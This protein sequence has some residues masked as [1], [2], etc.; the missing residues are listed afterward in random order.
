[1][2]KVNRRG[3]WL[4]AGALLAALIVLLAFSAWQVSRARCFVLVGSVTCRVETVK[5]LVALSFDDGPTVQ[6]VEA[7]L[8]ALDRAKVKATFFLIGADAEKRP[9]LV[10]RL[11]AAGH[12]IANHSYSHERMVGHSS[13]F[14]EE[15]IARTDA[16]LRKSGA[17]APRLFRPPYGKKLL[18]L[19]RAVER[20]GYRM[21]T[22]DVEDPS[23]GGGN[24]A[25]YAG[26]VVA[27]ARPGSIILM[28]PMYEANR[29]ARDALPLVLEGLKARGFHVVT[30][31]ELLREP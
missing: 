1:M 31:G 30:V 11:A 8:A 13:R 24:A 27:E 29:P 4:W 6:G 21:V 19:P 12:E 15:E 20:S 22:W 14:Y 2:G 5:P 28:H 17:A 18:G 23:D 25:G 26:Q 9:E 7:T 16:V 3:R 10:R